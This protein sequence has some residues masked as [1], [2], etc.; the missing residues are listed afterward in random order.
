MKCSQKVQ[1]NCRAKMFSS[2]VGEHIY[3]WMGDL[4]D[5]VSVCATMFGVCTSLG[6]GVMQLNSGIE[7]LNSDIEVSTTNQVIIIWAITAGYILQHS[8]CPNFMGA[9]PSLVPSRLGTQWHFEQEACMP[10]SV[11]FLPAPTPQ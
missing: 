5:I 8:H 7:R 9:A 6:F 11:L 1:G 4:V 2:C 10:L 3:G